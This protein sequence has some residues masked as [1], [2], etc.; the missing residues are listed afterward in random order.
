MRRAQTSKITAMA[1][2]C[3]R[4]TAAAVAPHGCGFFEKELMIV[5]WSLWGALKE[6]SGIT[7]CRRHYWWRDRTNPRMFEVN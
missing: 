2:Y 4:S 1:Q 6:V 5:R 3:S 7:K